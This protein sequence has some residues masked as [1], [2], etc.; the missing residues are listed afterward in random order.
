MSDGLD[1]RR[2]TRVPFRI[3]VTLR[4][5]HLTVV[6]ADVRDLSLNGLYAAAAARLPPGSDCEVLLSLGGPDSRV[7]L[8]MRGRVTR[9]DRGGLAVEFVGMR[10]DSFDHLRNL[11][12]Y[13]SADHARIEEEFRAYL[14][15]LQNDGPVAESP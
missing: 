6:S 3:E 9:V 12:R 5:D 4:G 7:S 15:E 10:L 1:R 11:V 14:A 2:F 8:T 13:N